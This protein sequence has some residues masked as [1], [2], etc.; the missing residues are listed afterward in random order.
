MQRAS[1]C[2]SGP[3]PHPPRDISVRPPPKMSDSSFSLPKASVR[4]DISI[5]ADH[6]SHLF[7]IQLISLFLESLVFG[8][9]TVLYAIAVWILLYRER[10]RNRTFLNKM[11]FAVSTIMWLLSLA[12]R[13]P[14]YAL[15]VSVDEIFHYSICR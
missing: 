12:V 5:C 9:F 4:F 15:C 11:L 13:L 7:I 10:A 8:A 14:L 1:W 6:G 3:P 2:V